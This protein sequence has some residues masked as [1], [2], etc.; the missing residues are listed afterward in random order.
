MRIKEEVK[1][2]EQ[3][4]RTYIAEDGKEFQYESECRDYEERLH[5][6]EKVKGAEELRIETLDQLTPIMYN[7]YLNNDNV[8]IW[9]K[10]ESENDLKTLE[11]AYNV[12]N[13]LDI[14]SYPELVCVESIYAPYESADD[15]YWYTLTSCKTDTEAFWKTMGYKVTLEKM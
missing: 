7:D 1:V 13:V 2:V 8:F 4:V 11:E 5:F 15:V 12:F 9:Y 6:T 3:T 14:N 10:V